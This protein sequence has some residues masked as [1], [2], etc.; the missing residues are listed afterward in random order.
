MH[1]SDL[2]LAVSIYFVDLLLVFIKTLRI[3]VFSLKHWRC[4]VAVLAFV[5]EE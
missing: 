3:T 4:I 1:V 2:L 5:A